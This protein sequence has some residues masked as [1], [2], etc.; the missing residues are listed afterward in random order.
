[1]TRQHKK[2]Q[3]KANKHLLYTNWLSLDPFC[4]DDIPLW[5]W[6]WPIV[7]QTRIKAHRSLWKKCRSASCGYRPTRVKWPSVCAKDK[8]IQ[9]IDKKG[10]SWMSWK[11]RKLGFQWWSDQWVISLTYKWGIPWGKKSHWSD[12]LLILTS[13]QQDI[14]VGVMRLGPTSWDFKGPKTPSKANLK[15]NRLGVASLEPTLHKAIYVLGRWKALGGLFHPQIS[16]DSVASLPNWNQ[17]MTWFLGFWV[18]RNCLRTF[19]RKD[20]K[21]PF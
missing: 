14:Q 11:G 16:H 4:F 15:A 20:V 6:S 8:L 19:K 18:W 12:H 3:K 2:L 10:T 7:E 9:K 1:V 5:K 17:S 21:E 13:F